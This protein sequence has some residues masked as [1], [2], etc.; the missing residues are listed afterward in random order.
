[1]G[2]A[3]QFA[4]VV[5]KGPVTERDLELVEEDVED[6]PWRA[7]PERGRVEELAI[8]IDELFLLAAPHRAQD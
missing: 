3:H 2:D 5:G 6:L 7:E 4:V 8:E 1:M